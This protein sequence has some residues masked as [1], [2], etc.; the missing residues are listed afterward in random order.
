[1]A[2]AR[3]GALEAHRAGALHLRDL[4]DLAQQILG[5]GLI[6]RYEAD[7]VAAGLV[8]A[9]REGGDV[10]AGFAEQR[11]ETA[12]EAR[13]VVVADV[14]HVGREF[15]VDEDVADLGHARL[16]VLEHGAARMARHVIG[17]H[18]DA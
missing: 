9:E 14:D 16:A 17:I 2:A 13:F 7:G 18:D 10:D 15:S 3:Y 11:T 12:D 6:H 1:M 8:A 4:L 5:Y